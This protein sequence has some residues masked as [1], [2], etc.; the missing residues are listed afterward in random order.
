MSRSLISSARSAFQSG[1]NTFRAARG[2]SAS[3]TSRPRSA[4]NRN[5][6][7][8]ENANFRRRCAQTMIPLHD[9]VAGATLISHLAVNSRSRSAL[10]LERCCRWIW[11]FCQGSIRGLYPSGESGQDQKKVQT[12]GLLLHPWKRQ[13][14]SRLLWHTVELP[15]DYQNF[16]NN[17]YDVASL[18][19]GDGSCGGGW[20]LYGWTIHSDTKCSR[21]VT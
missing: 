1:G 18:S 5:P 13:R 19:S 11:E 6:A 21:C 3:S 14:S 10:S 20:G 9:A 17:E 8:N 15:D 16:M 4:F 12:S 2:H 7:R